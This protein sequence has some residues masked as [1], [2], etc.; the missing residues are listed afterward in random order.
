MLAQKKIPFGFSSRCLA[1]MRMLLSMS[2]LIRLPVFRG[3]TKTEELSRRGVFLPSFVRKL[4]TPPKRNPSLGVDPFPRRLAKRPPCSLERF[5]LKAFAK[6]KEWRHLRHHLH[7][8]AL[9]P[10]EGP[11]DQAAMPPRRGL[12]RSSPWL[13]V[14]GGESSPAF[15]GSSNYIYIY[16]YIYKCGAP[17]GAIHFFDFWGMPSL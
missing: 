7:A 17:E 8:L 16:I 12:G 15:G 1:T 14:L 13:L 10:A 6:S 5:D 4:A 2:G 11:E 9:H 3:A